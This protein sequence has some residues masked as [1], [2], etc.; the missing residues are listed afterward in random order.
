MNRIFQFFV[1][2]VLIIA[3]LSY[4]QIWNSL[5][6]GNYNVGFKVLSLNDSTRT[7]NDQL[8]FRPVQ[9]SVWYPAEKAAV[10]KSMSYKDYFSL[11]ASEI[12]YNTTPE[13]KDSLITEYK[14]LLAQNGINNETVDEWFN[15]KMIAEK[16]ANPINEKFPLVVVAQ[17]NFHSAHHQAFLCEFLASY[18]YVV[19]TMPSQTRIT[20]QLTD[21]T[22][23]IKS[24]EE[25]VK[26][27]QLAI[28]SGKNF[29]NVSTNKIAL[30]GHSFGGR[31]ILLL[32]MIDE[33]VKCIVSFDGGLGLNT[34][35]E[36]IEKS[37]F[38]N[39]DKMDVP[40]LHFYE[41]SEE[42][43]KPDFRLI[44]SFNKSQ[45]FL[46]KIE[47]M[48]H[49][50]FSSFGLVSGTLKGFSPASENLA[51]KYKLI[52]DFTRDFL[53]AIFNDDQNGLDKLKEIF[54]SIAEKSKLISFTYR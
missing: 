18:G 7:I 47:D 29:D 28:T 46:I 22:Q 1:L 49:F 31:S 41:D 32:Q 20:G 35:V 23:A 50:Y 40:L 33:N 3:P 16:D 13:Q 19:I 9:V 10:L 4:C 34:A 48:H 43:I 38:Y 26:D 39:K 8:N 5:D 36:D 54:S 21:D 44:D 6:R 52:C 51:S 30:A 17:G 2:T 24:M 27:L 53:D 37:N 11:S 12:N 42:F 25:Q 14:N 15:N 45:R